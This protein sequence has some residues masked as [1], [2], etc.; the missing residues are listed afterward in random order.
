MVL[1]IGTALPVGIVGGLF[2]MVNNALYKSG[3]FLTGGAVE[4]QAGTTDL[5]KLGGLAA[6]MPVTFACFLVTAVSICGVPPFNGFF[7]KELVYDAALQRHVVFYLAALLGSFFTAASFLKLGHAAYLGKRAPANDNVKE[8]PASMLAPMIVI[9]ALCVLFGVYNALPINHLIQPALGEARLEGHS[10]AG[11]PGNVLLV[12]LTL[13][14]LGGALLNHL[15]G[16]KHTGSGLRAVDHVHYA[17]VLKTIYAK[18]E[19]RAFDPYDIGLRGAMGLAQAAWEADRAV[20]WLYD[21][22]AVG[23]AGGFSRVVRVAHSGD[24]ATYVL[25]ALA[26]AAAVIVFLA[27]SV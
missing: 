21:R 16:A 4:K 11:M 12:V 25:W 7:S 24:Y 17:P 6:R 20:D 23:L 8:A 19:R 10:F 9:A 13:V 18:A 27:R 14:A 5:A 22:F 2:H 3:L 26:G 15:F 1:G